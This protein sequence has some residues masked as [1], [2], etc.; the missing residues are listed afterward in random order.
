MAGIGLTTLPIL[1][2]RRWQSG[3]Q[4]R[5]LTVQ[6]DAPN[7]ISQIQPRPPP[8]RLSL[9][10]S[11]LAVLLDANVVE[12]SGVVLGVWSG[13]IRCLLC[14]CSMQSLSCCHGAHTL[15]PAFSS[16]V[17]RGRMCDSDEHLRSVLSTRN[18]WSPA[19]T[20]AGLHDGGQC[21][22]RSY[23]GAVSSPTPSC[24]TVLPSAFRAPNHWLVTSVLCHAKSRRIL[25]V[26]NQ[27]M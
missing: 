15:S 12:Y 9:T 6:A 7:N 8:L 26:R 18:H 14:V 13:L 4:K 3:S 22:Y 25:E 24:D 1:L 17:V 23:P 10:S 16:M 20:T 27:Q 21:H 19:D 11:R 5:W 2:L